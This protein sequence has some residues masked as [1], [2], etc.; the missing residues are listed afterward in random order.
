MKAFRLGLVACSLMAFSGAASAD[1]SK[2][3]ADAVKKQAETKMF[4][5]ETSMITQN[6][7]AKMTIEVVAPDRMR[8]VVTLVTDPKPVETILVGGKAWSRTDGGEWTKLGAEDT[9][10]LFQFFQNTIGRSNADVGK[11]KCIGIEPVEG[12]KLRGY[13]GIEDDKPGLPGKNQGTNVK[14][15]AERVIYLDPATGQLVR[16]IFAQKGKRDKPIFAEVYSY[17]TDITIDAPKVN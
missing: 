12:V 13:L 15:E 9:G 16:T 5:K 1:C 6:G 2:E 10:Q 7:P 8:Q 3:V 4:R 17:P 14:N 11:F